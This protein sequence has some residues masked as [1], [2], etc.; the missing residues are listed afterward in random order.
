MRISVLAI[1]VFMATFFQVLPARAGEWV[2]PASLESLSCIP[3]LPDLF[4]FAD[5]RRVKTAGSWQLRRKEMK[6]MLQYYQYGHLPP[7]PDQITVEDFKSRSIPDLQTT[8]ERITLVIGSQAQLRMRIAVYLPPNP[9]RRP[10]I[11]REAPKLGHIKEVPLLMERGFILVKFART[12]LDPDKND[13]VCPAQRVYPNYDW[14]TLAVWA[15]GGMR[16]VD[17]LETRDDVDLERIGITGHSRGG[18]TALLAGALD[19]R[20]SLVA[21]NGSGCGGAGCYRV[22]GENSETLEKITDPKRF[23][24]WFHPRFRWF[25]D[26]EDRL[27]F[28]QHFLKALVAP[29]ALICTDARGDKWANPPGT[30]AT[31]E[32]AQKAFEFLNAGNK[33]GLHFRDGGHQFSSD[34]WQAILDFAEWQ[35]F[36]K[37]PENPDR[38]RLDSLSAGDSRKNTDSEKE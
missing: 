29:R 31:S 27:P 2:P 12:D 30:Q 21:P 28:D 7:R 25:S 5:G 16:V 6:A 17:Y 19:E 22:Q 35:F 1:T 13:V 24:Y 9:G 11:V 38:F 37:Q 15:W 32:A 8:E 33:N 36:G 23:S 18:K 20:F 10:V 14:A 34:D 3:E 4:T 26:R